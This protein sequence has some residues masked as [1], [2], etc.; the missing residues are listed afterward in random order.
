MSTTNKRWT[1]SNGDICERSPRK[2]REEEHCLPA[3]SAEHAQ[4]QAL[5]SENDIW[6]ID[7]PVPINK[8]EDTYNRISEREMICQTG[9]NPFMSENNYLKDLM[10]HDSF[11]KPQNTTDGR[12]KRTDV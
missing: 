6:S 10:V 5:L 8:R 1:W 3:Q 4:N 11:M 9:K 2:R 7:E 12:E